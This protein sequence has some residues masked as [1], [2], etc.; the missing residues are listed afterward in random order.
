MMPSLHQQSRQLM[1][2]HTIAFIFPM[3]SGHINPSLPV[4]RMLVDLGHKVHYLCREQMQEAIEDTGASFHADTE[5]ETELYSGREPDLFGALEALK[6]EFNLEQDNHVHAMTKLKTI[7]VEMKLPGVLRWLRSI[8]ASAVVYCPLMNDEAVY[9]AHALGIPSIA[10]LTTAG[11]GSLPPT[12]LEFIGM[13]GATVES[14]RSAAESYQPHC[15]A[16]QR[17]NSKYGLDCS[18]VQNMKPIGKLDNL[19]YSV[20]TLVTTCEDL[21][22]PTPP[23]VME[24][25]A[26][27]RVRFEAVGPLL[28]KEGARRAAGHK[29][30]GSDAEKQP[31][32]AAAADNGHGS[33]SEKLMQQVRAA[34]VEGRS[35]ILVSMGT[36]ITGD[37]PDMGWEGRMVGKD[38][39]KRGLTG[40]ELC[41]AAWAAAFDVFGRP[42]AGEG[43]LL[44]V[45]LGPQPDALGDLVVPANA[46]CASVVPQVDVLREGVNI[47][48][49]HGGQ[50]SF[51]EGLA[52]AAP[53]VVC[54]GFGDQVVNARKA[55]TLGIGLSVLRPDCEEGGEATAAAEYRG[56]VAAA[57]RHVADEEKFCSA[58]RGC[59]ERLGQTGGV[60]R[61]VEVIVAAASRHTSAK[62]QK[63]EDATAEALPV[64]GAAIKAG[65]A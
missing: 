18:I 2:K 20:A 41:R 23:E 31:A 36:V 54:P 55:E 47:F 45:A 4:A 22:D 58:A 62:G 21:Q 42:S 14:V 25:Y 64:A 52:S 1:E 6:R 39:K 13:F 24:A 65:G 44:I 48:L 3:A 46:L 7:M 53:L 61:M 63:V 59:A 30:R 26:A 11:A 38:G 35:V 40:R 5:Q 50:N 33:D 9:A 12:M 16:V 32:P 57:L 19:K 37:S 15:E 60:P 43:A 49:T 8:K 34:R 51:T 10:L 28:D 17:I 27:D 56:E 29:F